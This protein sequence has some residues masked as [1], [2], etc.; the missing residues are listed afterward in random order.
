MK[1]WSAQP[2]RKS[3]TSSERPSLGEGRC[4]RPLCLVP[5]A[6]LAVTAASSLLLSLSFPDPSRE[7]RRAVSV[8]PGWCRQE[9]FP[10]SW[11]RATPPCT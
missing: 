2:L 3:G 10:F 9:A 8:L 4:E 11:L 5:A 1:L 6:R 7:G